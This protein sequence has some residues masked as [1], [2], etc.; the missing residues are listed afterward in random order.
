MSKSKNKYKY[1]ND[2][3]KNKRKENINMPKII[4]ITRKLEFYPI[5]ELRNEFYSF[6][7]KHSYLQTIAKQM[8][9]NKSVQNVETINSITK[10]EKMYQDELMVLKNDT[11]LAYQD[12]QNLDKEDKNYSKKLSK[13]NKLIEKN[14]SK[15]NVLLSKRNASARATFQQAIGANESKIIDDMV[16]ES[17]DE[18]GVKLKE[19]ADRTTYLYTGTYMGKQDFKNDIKDGLLQGK[20]A[21]RNYNT[22]NDLNLIQSQLRDIRKE[23]DGHYYFNI[24]GYK[25]KVV[26]G[27]KPS[28]ATQAKQ[29]LEDV[30]SHKVVKVCDSKIKKVKDKFFLLL[31]L[32]INV[33]QPVLD[34]EKIMGIDLGMDIPAYVAMEFNEKISRAFGE[35]KE[36]LNFKTKIKKMKDLEKHR[37]VY[38][39]GGHGRK[40]KMK[41]N[42]LEALRSRES[43]FSKTY[44]HTISKNIVDYAIKFRVGKIRMEKL[45]S[46]GFPN[47]KMLGNWTY[48]MLQQMIETKASKNGIVVEYVNPAYTSKT[49]SNCGSVKENYELGNRD[50]ADGRQFHCNRC[51]NKLNCDHNA[52]INISRGGVV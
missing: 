42:H 31:V 29:T 28:L 37:S 7:N 12:I 49:C 26:L 34:E 11:D 1:K 44:N 30:I 35:K 15:R 22:F 6:F 10:I 47:T 27:R 19:K 8:A 25:L 14:T 23:D 17:E 24:H 38:S 40:R 9:Y 18:Y 39:K 5:G 4:T 52:A 50:G 51:E 36:L 20:R 13:L 2:T 41:N 32:N 48:Y 33:E 46:K 21:T 43:N 45:D 16:M 3:I